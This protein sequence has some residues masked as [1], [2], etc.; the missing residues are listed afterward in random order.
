L[1]CAWFKLIEALSEL[2]EINLRKSSENSTFMVMGYERGS[3]RGGGVFYWNPEQKEDNGYNIIS[4]RN[5]GH[6]VRIYENE[7]NIS[8]VGGEPGRNITDALNSL[9]EL[10][11]KQEGLT[12]TIILGPYQYLIDE[13]LKCLPSCV[14]L[15]GHWGRTVLEYVGRKG[16]VMLKAVSPIS[17]KPV[18]GIKIDGI[19]LNLNFTPDVI[20]LQCIYSTGSSVIGNIRVMNVAA[21][22]VGIDISMQWYAF[23]GNLEIV[24][25]LDG[26]KGGVGLRL[27]GDKKIGRNSQVNGIKFPKT[28]IKNF[29]YGIL[30][31]TTYA[32][33]YSLD[34][35][36]V[37]EKCSV[38][39]KHQGKFGVGKASFR[40]HFEGNDHNIIWSTPYSY[41]RIAGQIQWS[42]YSRSGDFMFS[43][44]HHI[45]ANRVG[46]KK[47]S[48][49]MSEP[50]R[51]EW[52]GAAVS[53]EGNYP[54]T[55]IPMI[56]FANLVI[57]PGYRQSS[58]KYALPEGNYSKSGT[59]VYKYSGHDTLSA[60]SEYILVVNGRARARVD[61]A[62]LV[63]DADES[64]IWSGYIDV[65]EDK[66]RIFKLAGSE[67]DETFD[68][69]LTHNG[70]LLH[71]G[72]FVGHASILIVP[73]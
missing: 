68:L 45:V 33:A 60:L 24:N 47:A 22:G 56:N 62:V 29:E 5:K 10:F 19:T 63:D 8:S 73:L 53:A 69:R 52:H 2:R 71:S 64:R 66:W 51:V 58:Q 34:F 3:Y 37:I 41:P 32:G 39:I 43:H 28:Q 6:F 13:R 27:R 17:G 72:S 61:V 57:S 16:N 7:I 44:G 35:D 65:A 4:S 12:R 14:T 31:D 46:D 49:Y 40:Y 15:R 25:S 1:G 36:V 20:G 67:F 23:W 54:G 70:D 48:V 26:I 18:R 38:G 9:F 59:F 11:R 55:K 42:G 21:D 50:A 30:L